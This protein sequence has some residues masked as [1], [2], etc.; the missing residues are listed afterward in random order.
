MVDC[1]RCGAEAADPQACPECGGVYCPDHGSPV[2]H[3]CPAVAAGVAEG[4]FD[5]ESEPRRRSRL[6]AAA[7]WTGVAVVT[8]LSLML[9]GVATGMITTGPVTG[10]T[11]DRGLTGPGVDPTPTTTPVPDPGTVRA[12][13]R[14]NLNDWRV[15]RGRDRLERAPDRRAV[16]DEFAA[17]LA[18]VDYF[19]NDSLDRSRY[20]PRGRL[21]ESGH[22]CPAVAHG[23]L[24]LPPDDG[25]QTAT[26]YGRDAAE[27]IRA[28]LTDKPGYQYTA[29]HAVGVHVVDGTVYVVYVAC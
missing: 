24:R 23:L 17:D 28:G 20:S 22:D 16:L 12:V 11:H 26:D 2:T 3:E 19:T 4:A 1:E 27:T 10:D 6:H 5:P 9:V 13:V 25:R 14:K 15:E 18:R 21:R 29:V 7:V 8:V